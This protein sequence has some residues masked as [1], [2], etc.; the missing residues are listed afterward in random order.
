VRECRKTEL[1]RTGHR[2]QYG[3]CA[4]CTGYLRL[5]T[6]LQNMSYVLRFHCN[7]GYTNVTHCYVIRT[8]NCLSLIFVYYSKCLLKTNNKILF[9]FVTKKAVCFCE[10]G[11]KVQKVI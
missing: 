5:Q 10:E 4:L 2:Q 9:I 11:I 7:N 1:S 3:A 8:V 6:H